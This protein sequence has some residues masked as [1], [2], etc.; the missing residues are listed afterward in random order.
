M[1]KE[2]TAISDEAR[3]FLD[4]SLWG[5]AQNDLGPSAQDYGDLTYWAPTVNMDR[6]PRW[7]RTD[8]AF[9]EDPYLVSRMAGAFV[10]GYQGETL[11]GKPLTKYL[12]VAATAKHYALNDVENDRQADDSVTND[13]NIRDYYTA[14]FRSLFENAHVSGFMTSYN[15]V[16]GTPASADTY[17]A[18]ELAQ[19][20]YGSERLHDF[21][22]RRGRHDLSE[23]ALRSRL[24]SAG[25][26]HRRRRLKRRVDQ[27]PVR[28][29]G[30]RSRRRAGVR[31]PSRHRPQLH[32]C[33]IHPAEHPAGHQ[34]GDPEQGGHR[35]RPYARASRRGWRPASSTPARTFRGRRSSQTSSRARRI[36]RSPGRSPTTRWCC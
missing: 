7:G 5:K 18:N 12:K 25:L 17:T 22:L 23:S 16:N 36:R 32:R 28:Q 30:L 20:T 29:A 34:S 3:G 14:Q 10:D 11:S 35:Q 15:A 13:A 21:R 31:G 8:E 33:R 26:G 2:T 1:Y 9:G 27:P 4:P 24:G 19:R 6:D